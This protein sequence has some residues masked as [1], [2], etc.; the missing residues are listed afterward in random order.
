MLKGAKKILK[1][2]KPKYIQ[3]EL[4]WHHLFKGYNLWIIYEYISQF[5]NY[6]VYKILPNSSIPLEIDPSKHLPN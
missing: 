6:K 1:Q 3:V 5:A 2:F 4:N